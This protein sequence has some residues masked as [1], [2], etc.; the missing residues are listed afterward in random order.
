MPPYNTHYFYRD[1]SRSH[2]M[3]DWSGLKGGQIPG[4]LITL[5][6]LFSTAIDASQAGTVHVSTAELQEEVSLARDWKFHWGD[7]LRWASPAFDDR[8][9]DSYPV[10]ERWPKLGRARSQQFSWYRLRI[11]L[12]E[13]PSTAPED[14]PQLG[15]QIGK[16]LSAYELYAGGKLVGTVGRLPPHSEVNYDSI[17]V[18]P[19]PTSA[20]AA[21]GTLLLAMRVWGGS[22][23][24]I[25]K[26][27]GG[28]HEG[29]FRLGYFDTLLYSSFIDEIPGLMMFTLF[30]G[31]GLY[32]IYLYLRNRQL[33]TYLWYGLAAL[34]IGVYSFLSSQLRYSLDWSFP[35]YEKIEFSTI[36]LLP[37]LLI[38]MLWSLLGSPV[39]R[40]L[41]AYQLCFVAFSLAILCVPGISILYHTL[42]PWEFMCLPLIVWIPWLIVRGA[43]AGNDEARTTMIG[44]VIFVAAGAN[45]L[46][47]DIAGWQT[48][49]VLPFGFVAIMLSMAISLANRFTTVLN[50]LEEEVA[51]RTTDLRS[52]N[53][54]LAAVARQ[55][56][57]TGLLNRRGFTELATAEMRRYVRTGRTFSIVLADLDNFKKFN[58]QYGH[59][60]GDYV[61][62]E[63]ARLLGERVR[64]MDVVAR[65][66][67]EEFMIMIPETTQEGAVLLAEN[68]RVSLEENHFQHEGQQAL[69]TMTLGVS[70]YQKDEPLDSCIARADQALYA[71]KKRGRNQV[72][73][74]DHA[75]PAQ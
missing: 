72:N 68:L 29:Q 37:A 32:H 46:M 26:W 48:I 6:L 52:A 27:G 23:L 64:K 12:E 28:P 15:V 19:V 36:Y 43:L 40:L 58:D 71:G 60:F 39:G 44:L 63:V 8:S 24:A 1:T 57:L 65:W 73:A 31:F 10:P 45:D 4:F 5:M 67:G 2:I 41:R 3:A 62:Q 11:Q 70:S 59:A 14:H 38:Q 69:V 16:V 53:K 56:P 47:I 20:I 30:T 42:L 22:E 17:R 61:L 9:W 18:F 21:D 74:G 66:G 34:N 49:R 7:D 33:R 50:N 13:L 55:D 25:S 54:Q 51:Q 35:V 75:R